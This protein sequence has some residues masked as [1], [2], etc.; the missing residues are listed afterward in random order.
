MNLCSLGEEHL[1]RRPGAGLCDLEEPKRLDKDD[2]SSANILGCL[3]PLD[4]L[5]GSSVG[6]TV[7]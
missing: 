1:P 7:N 6:F 3:C 5:G 4:Y 2:V